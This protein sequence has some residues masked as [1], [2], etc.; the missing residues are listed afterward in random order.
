[1]GGAASHS[2]VTE[3][4]EEGP[5]EEEEEEEEC[6]WSNRRWMVVRGRTRISVSVD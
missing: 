3:E 5:E 4:E 6:R 1:M 2:R